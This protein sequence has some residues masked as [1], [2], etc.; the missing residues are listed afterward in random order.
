MEQKFREFL[1]RLF[2]QMSTG[3]FTIMVQCADDKEFSAEVIGYS[4][5]YMTIEVRFHSDELTK[6]GVERVPRH[7][8]GFGGPGDDN[9]DLVPVRVPVKKERVWFENIRLK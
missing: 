5:E 7:G 9:Y 6:P 1:I 3:D 8:F 4:E 2:T